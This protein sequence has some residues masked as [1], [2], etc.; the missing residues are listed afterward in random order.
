VKRGPVPPA[1]TAL[2]REI[3]FGYPPPLPRRPA[4]CTPPSWRPLIV[5]S[6][7]QTRGAY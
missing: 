4:W 6:S 5:C 1:A 3:A 7:P 2:R